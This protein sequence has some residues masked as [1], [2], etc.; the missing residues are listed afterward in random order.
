MLDLEP[1]G[2]VSHLPG[3]RRDLSVA[4]ANDDDAETIGGGCAPPSDPKPAWRRSDER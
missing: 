1:Y 4:V 3:V 2:P